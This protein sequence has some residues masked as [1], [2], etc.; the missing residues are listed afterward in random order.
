M[1]YSV[2]TTAM[3]KSTAVLRSC[4][5]SKEARAM[6]A[7]PFTMSPIMPVHFPS[8]KPP[9][10]PSLVAKHVDL[11]KESSRRLIAS[12][13]DAITYIFTAK[14]KNRC[15]EMVLGKILYNSFFNA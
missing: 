3:R 10:C 13:T 9:H 14:K 8:F 11:C 2:L 4:V 5:I 6:S 12:A 15:Y 1:A 7:L